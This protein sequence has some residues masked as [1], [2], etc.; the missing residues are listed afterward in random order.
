[1]HGRSLQ[2]PAQVHRIQFEED[3]AGYFAGLVA[4]AV[5]K[6][7]KI[8]SSAASTTTRRSSAT[9]RATR[10]APRP[11]TQHQRPDGLLLHRRHHQGLRRSDLGQDL[12]RPVHRHAEGRRRLPG[13]RRH[14]QRCSRFGC[15][16]KIIGI[17]VDVDQY[18]SYPSADACIV[19]SA[20]ST[21]P[22]RS[23]RRSPRSPAAPP[24]AASPSSMRPMTALATR[25]STTPPSRSQPTCRA[26][27]TLPS[28]G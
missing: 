5:S 15:A 14:R 8:G 3:Q 19:T 11:T 16:K 25:R 27:S 23:S 24:R 1:M 21:S 22:A 9:C 20:R 17:G 2:V 26:S 7:G 12:Q 10:S 13:G 4:A 28:P 6:T 18:L